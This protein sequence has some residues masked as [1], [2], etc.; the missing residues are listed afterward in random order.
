[1]AE[2]GLTVALT[3]EARRCNDCGRWWAIERGWA[4]DCPNCNHRLRVEAHKA[5]EAAERQARA[6]RGVLTRMKKRRGRGGE[7]G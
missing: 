2:L 6:L 3:L 1:M 4:G 7:H 5:A